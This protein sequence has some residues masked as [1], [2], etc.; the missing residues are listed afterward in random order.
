[1]KNSRDKD[2]NVAESLGFIFDDKKRTIG[3]VVTGK[4]WRMEL[5]ASTTFLGPGRTSALECV[6]IIRDLPL[7]GIELGSTHYHEGWSTLNK[8]P[9]IWQGRLF[10]HNFF[11]PARKEN[12][13][14]NLVNKYYFFL[15]K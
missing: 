13:V 4:N 11:P 3:S 8:I 9:E 7:Q 2:G 1:M 6:N 5:F 10:T 14:I 15:T 12:F